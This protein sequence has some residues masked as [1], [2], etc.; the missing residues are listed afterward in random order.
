MGCKRPLSR[1][2]ATVSLGCRQSSSSLTMGRICHRRARPTPAI[3]RAAPRR[4]TASPD[5]PFAALAKMGTG[6]FCPSQRIV[7]EL[8]ETR[9]HTK[10]VVQ[11]LA[12]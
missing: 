2:A 1:Y 9:W 7:H 8:V 6:Q 10:F 4:A 5:Q 3:Q 12:R 11:R